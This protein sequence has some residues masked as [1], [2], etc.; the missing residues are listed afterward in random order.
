M[1]AVDWNAAARVDSYSGV[2]RAGFQRNIVPRGVPA[3]MRGLVS[4]WPL[5][6]A[7]RRSPKAALD[8]FASLDERRPVEIFSAPPE[9]GGR[10]FYNAQLD[11]SNFERKRTT[12]AELAAMLV[13]SKDDPTAP[14][15]YAGA[16]PIRDVIPR[17]LP[18]I[19][20]G[21]IDPA[22]EQLISLWVGNRTR[23]AAHWDLPQNL[24]C[25]VAGRRRYIVLPPEELP[26]LYVGP[27][28]FTLA[29]QPLSLVDFLDPDLDAHPKF[30]A[31]ARR[32]QVAVLEPG[33]ALYLPSMWWHHAESLDAI[34]VMVNFWWRDGPQ[35]LTTPLAAL[36]HAAL[37]L[38]DLPER[39]RAVWRRFFDHYI[40]GVNG[41]PFAHL[42]EDKRGVMGPATPERIARIKALVARS[43]E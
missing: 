14:S 3:V 32:A 37:T 2:D 21:V 33:D 34:G 18:E 22:R 31:A 29:G 23:V 13:R 17:L 36:L 43:V 35:H 30:A 6:E 9:I 4:G 25:N 28:D 40:F 5:V 7:A 1:S 11:G 42:P 10:F 27:L 38:R 19:S 26:N 15:V 41:D 16:T 39:E 24:I 20:N 8:H 12:L